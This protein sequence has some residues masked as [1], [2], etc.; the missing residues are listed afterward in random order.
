MISTGPQSLHDPP[1]QALRDGSSNTRPTPPYFANI[2]VSCL[3]DWLNLTGPKSTESDTFETL[4]HYFPDL[5]PASGGAKMYGSR[6]HSPTTP[7]LAFLHDHTTS[8][9]WKVQLSGESLSTLRLDGL[10]AL[11]SD[12]N[13]ADLRCTRID[14]AIDLMAPDASLVDLTSHLERAAMVH[15]LRPC[16]SHL[17]M[18]ERDG[19]QLRSDTL[20]H[21]TSRSRVQLR[22]YDK[23]LQ[24]SEGLAPAGEWI[25]WE[26]EFRREKAQST[27][28]RF[29]ESP[30][31]E[32][33]RSY[34]AGVI[35]ACP[36][37]IEG[38]PTLLSQYPLSATPDR[39]SPSAERWIRYFRTSVAPRLQAIADE[40]DVPLLRLL[41]NSPLLKG[42]EVSGDVRSH[43]IVRHC[44]A[45]WSDV[46]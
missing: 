30:T 24:T 22:V 25:R 16:R 36:E 33:I 32:T 14:L 12:L 18:C 43:P 26:V 7:G 10:N 9:R 40:L 21:G 23:G 45:A 3:V 13:H 19:D 34:A 2:A 27:F 6:S 37:P 15:A 35:E 4:K 1:D 29:M 17:R 28:E 11:L 41:E 8:D 42:I 39:G 20:Y 38:L 31:L 46:T 5:Q 44:A